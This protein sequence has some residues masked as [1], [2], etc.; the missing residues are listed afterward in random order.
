MKNKKYSILVFL[1]IILS[2]GLVTMSAALYTSISKKSNLE[3]KYESLKEDYDSLEE[4]K[5]SIEN[6]YNRFTNYV[7]QLNQP[8][9]IDASTFA[10]NGVVRGFKFGEPIPYDKTI[11]SV[12][13]PKKDTSGLLDM[14]HDKELFK[15]VSVT[16]AINNEGSSDIALNP[17]KFFVSDEDDEFLV[18]DSVFSI[19]NTIII[20]SDSSV[21]IKAGKEGYVTIVFA[22]K[23][24]DAS[25]EVTKVQF[26]NSYFTK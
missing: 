10:I 24:E 22:M 13:E 19:N 15:R 7:F 18:F 25:K 21:V 26:G 23:Q 6:L 8:L 16:L 5:E 9:A 11:I 2:I 12:G 17:R 14:K 4:S 1:T 20:E 3:E